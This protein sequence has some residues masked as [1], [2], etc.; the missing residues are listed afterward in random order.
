MSDLIWTATGSKGDASLQGNCGDAD[1][2]FCRV[3]T[4]RPE[5]ITVVDNPD[6]ARGPEKMFRFE[7]RFG[8]VYSYYSDSRCLITG[9]GK[10]W[11]D[12]DVETWWR[13]WTYQPSD[14]IGAYPKWDE[15]MSW[16]G[17]SAGAGSGMEWHHEPYG[18]G[19]ENGSAPIYTG[20]S[21]DSL[22]LGL[23][24]APPNNTAGRQKWTRAM[25]RGR[26][27]EWL[28]HAY[29][30]P[31][32]AKGYLEVWIDGEMW[33]QR[34]QT[35]TMFPNCRTYPVLGLYRNGRIGDPSL[36]WP[37]NGRGDI[38][39]PHGFVPKKGQRVYTR[40]DGYPGAQLI[41]GLAVGYTREA[42]MNAYPVRGGPA[43]PQPTSPPVADN[44]TP[45]AAPAVEPLAQNLN[46]DKVDSW[47][48]QLINQRAQLEP[49]VGQL[50]AALATLTQLRDTA[51]KVLDDTAAVLNKGQ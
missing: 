19:I 51:R 50:D 22:W 23:V 25:V 40:D 7:V 3:Q 33:I 6:P 15:L 39:Y 21:D 34:F 10:L 42:V 36:T 5:S 24:E 48:M 1:N 8:D 18:G 17:V 27:Y 43:L 49:V 31:D 9:P 46:R 32:P 41:G 2:E 13:W 12:K 45:A 47:R 35:Y 37:D 29:W 44:P 28:F 11:H 20:V 38:N 14:W 26:I 30:S 16:P 4:P